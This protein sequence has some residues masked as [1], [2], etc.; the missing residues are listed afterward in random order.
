MT[1][2]QIVVTSSTEGNRRNAKKSQSVAKVEWAPAPRVKV[3][4]GKINGREG[5]MLVNLC[6]KRVQLIFGQ[7]HRW[8]T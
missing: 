4:R 5:V 2:K 7:G 3:F 6:L 8:L 1:L